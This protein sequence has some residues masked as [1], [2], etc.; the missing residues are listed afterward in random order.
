MPPLTCPASG[1]D[2]ALSDG[3]G[4][5]CQL[6]GHWQLSQKTGSC[7]GGVDHKLVDRSWWMLAQ[8]N[9]SSQG[10]WKEDVTLW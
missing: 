10:P 8:R 2:V 3:G 4:G 9:D 5:G 7:E 1:K 6:G